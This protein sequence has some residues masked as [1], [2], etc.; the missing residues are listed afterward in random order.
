MELLFKKKFTFINLTLE[1]TTFYKGLA[2]LIIIMHNFFHWVPPA[3]GENEQNFHP[4]RVDKYL[5]IVFNQPEYIF[6][7]TFSYLGHYGV[8]VFLFLS[9]YGLTVKYLNSDIQYFSYLKRRILKIYPAFLFSILVWLLYVGIMYG[10]LPVII[11][12]IVT[13]WEAIL[14]K[15]TFIANFIPNQLYKLN[16]PWWFVSLIVQFYILFPFMLFLFKKYSTKSLVI[17]S[18]SSLI[19]TAFLQPHLAIP[20]AG[21]IL[22]HIPELSI[23]IYFAQKKNFSINYVSILVI[24]AIFLLSNYY[25]LFWY[26]SFSSILILMLIMFQGI[27]LKINHSIKNIILFIGS[28][29]MYIFYING[30]MRYPW[31]RNA[32]E[33]DLWYTNIFI[34]FLSIS[35]VIVLSYL[36]MKIS[37]DLSKYY[38]KTDTIT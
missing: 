17:L 13:N 29:S 25:K 37:Q 6:Q 19:A 38:K 16:G 28:I 20:L 36:M 22:V 18:L 32:K 11:K 1:D 5:Q 26:L 8:Q 2:I 4:S 14:Y 33:Y 30:F 23:G 9:A 7:A 34:C 10:G 27:L 12:T 35:L 21:T 31:V 3:P 24:A 15:I